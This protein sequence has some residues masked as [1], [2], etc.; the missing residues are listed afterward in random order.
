MGGLRGLTGVVAV[1]VAAVF[2]IWPIGGTAS[3]TRSTA[4]ATYT[5]P[6]V[7]AGVTVIKTFHL[8]ELRAAVRAL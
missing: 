6:T 8:N 5:D 7:V 1:A 2:M 3:R 4:S